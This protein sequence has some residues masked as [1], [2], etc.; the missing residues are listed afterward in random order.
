MSRLKDKH[1]FSGVGCE[2]RVIQNCETLSWVDL[3]KTD[4]FLSLFFVLRL[5]SED[6]PTCPGGLSQKCRLGILKFEM[7]WLVLKYI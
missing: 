2:D 7:L 6:E 3:V 1:S 5:G 4:E